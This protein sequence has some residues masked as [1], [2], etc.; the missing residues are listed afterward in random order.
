[1]LIF[2]VFALLPHIITGEFQT[3]LQNFMS[4]HFKFYIGNLA[5]SSET[6]DIPHRLIQYFGTTASFSSE[7]LDFSFIGSPKLPIKYNHHKTR[8]HLF[9]FVHWYMVDSLGLSQESGDLSFK[10]YQS[11]SLGEKPDYFLFFEN[12]NYIE[13]HKYQ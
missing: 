2:W 8:K 5:E 7:E 3:L 10:M 1:M 9:C 6:F 4:C 12:N 13:F 11:E